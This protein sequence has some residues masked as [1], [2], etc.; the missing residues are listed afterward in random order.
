MFLTTDSTDWEVE[1]DVLGALGWGM[2]FEV[3]ATAKNAP[4]TS[5]STLEWVGAAVFI[6]EICG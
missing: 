1:R 6:R 5:R 2:K 4:G 3:L